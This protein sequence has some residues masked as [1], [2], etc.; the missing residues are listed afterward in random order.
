ME[1]VR[2]KLLKKDGWLFQEYPFSKDVLIAERTLGWY[3]ED[4]LEQ[5]RVG[6]KESGC[7]FFYDK[8][9][10]GSRRH[11]TRIEIYKRFETPDF[12]EKIASLKD[13]I[14]KCEAKC[15]FSKPI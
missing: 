6:L 9:G 13:I 8:E 3:D 14:D 15:G 5:I 4:R 10:K 12:E 7:R 2:A 1:N 11:T